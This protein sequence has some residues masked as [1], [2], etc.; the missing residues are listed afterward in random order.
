MYD[1][2]VRISKPDRLPHYEAVISTKNFHLFALTDLMM[3]YDAVFSICWA[4]RVAL[5]SLKIFLENHL[6][7]DIFSNY[8]MYEYDN[9]P[10]DLKSIFT[11][12]SS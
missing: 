4:Y 5:E 6:Y 8:L 10:F 12:W 1:L 3:F 7:F 9:A 2:R 11:L